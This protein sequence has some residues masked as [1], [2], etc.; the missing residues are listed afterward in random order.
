MAEAVLFWTFGGLTAGLALLVIVM[1]N[2]VHCAVALIGNLFCIAALFALLDAHFLAAIQV[3]V[4][5]GAILVL[6][7]F[8]I[9][10]LNLKPE[11][12]GGPRQ[13]ATKIAGS[14][15]LAW[16]GFKLVTNLVGVT[17]AG[18]GFGA[19]DASYGTVETV[20]R[21]L[22]GPYLLPFEVASILLLA[23]IMGSVAIAKKR[24]W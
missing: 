21:L 10:L 6:F 19:V 3:L 12:L 11:E 17:G 18:E 14:V 5:A 4:Y 2:P 24:L 16:V 23:A 7:L 22:F 1:R 9:M 20:G 15:L 13:T 8:V